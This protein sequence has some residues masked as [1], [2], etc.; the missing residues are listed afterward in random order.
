MSSNTTFADGLTIIVNTG[1]PGQPGA[2]GQ[3]GQAGAPGAPGGTGIEAPEG[4]AFALVDDTTLRVTLPGANGALKRADIALQA[5]EQPALP[6]PYTTLLAAAVAA[7]QAEGGD[8]HVVSADLATLYT[9]D[10]ATSAAA[11]GQDV[12][13]W[14]NRRSGGAAL[15]QPSAVD[16]PSLTTMATTGRAALSLA[17]AADWLQFNSGTG[18]S[19][20]WIF[21]GQRDAGA[22]SPAGLMGNRPTTNATAGVFLLAGTTGTGQLGIQMRIGDAAGYVS[23][24]AEAPITGPLVV[25]GRW[26]PTQGVLAVNGG[27][28]VTQA[29]QKDAT[30]AAAVSVGRLRPTVTTFPFVGKVALVARHATAFSASAR[31]AIERLGA[32]LTGATLAYDEAPT[33]ASLLPFKTSA[34]KYTDIPYSDKSFQEPTLGMQTLYCKLDL[35]LPSTPAPAGGYS[36]V[37]YCHANGSSKSITPGDNIDVRILQPLLAQGLAVAAIEFPH[38]SNQMA[39]AGVDG[40][41]VA[42]DAYNDIG[43]AF[44]KLRSIAPAVNLNPNDMGVV[45]RSRGSLALYAW[46][47]NNRQSSVGSHQDRQ[48]SWIQAFWVVNGQTVHRHS[49]ASQLFVLEAERAL[50]MS[51]KQE[52]PSLRDAVNLVLSAPYMPWVHL[53]ANGS[54]FNTLVT[55]AQANDVHFP[56][57]LRILAE[58]ARLVG[59]ASRVTDEDGVADVNEMVGMPAYFASKLNP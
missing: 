39:L 9:D 22:A 30:Q 24:E 49:T 19:G 7:V 12:A 28:E 58:R 44:Q 27:A 17:S 16:R 26:T 8:L 15:L 6:D 32:F 45:T 43:R 59:G 34:T 40:D 38:P 36:V 50:Y 51:T 48:S 2:P 33:A 1:L 3:P 35:Y 55:A 54:Y 41:P 52:W 42:L 31:R 47:A 5:V 21:A 46:L 11:Q 18:S 29:H 57:M 53:V 56:D 20:E 4:L 14:A 25:S 23:V 13:V 10:A 37:G